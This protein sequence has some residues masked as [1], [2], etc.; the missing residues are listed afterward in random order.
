MSA[1]TLRAPTA[2]AATGLG[3]LLADLIGG[4]R[5][6]LRIRRATAALNDLSPELLKDLGI[7]RSEIARVAR[8]GRRGS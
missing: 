2:A 1:T 6:H 5:E 3:R 8:F 7:E 4:L